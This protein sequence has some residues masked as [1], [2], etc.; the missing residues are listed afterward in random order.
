MTGGGYAP[1]GWGKN[2]TAEDCQAAKDPTLCQLIGA[3]DF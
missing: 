1:T 2:P 3:F